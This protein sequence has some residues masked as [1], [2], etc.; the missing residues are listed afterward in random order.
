MWHFFSSLLDLYVVIFVSFFFSDFLFIV[1]EH[2]II[3]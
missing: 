1:T 3:V 2:S